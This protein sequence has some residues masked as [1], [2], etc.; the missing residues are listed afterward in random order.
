MV[1][2]GKVKETFAVQSRVSP[3]D[4]YADCT[5]KLAVVSFSDQKF[6]WPSP[7]LPGGQKHGFPQHF[8]TLKI[9]CRRAADAKLQR[10]CHKLDITA[11]GAK[12]KALERS[13][14]LGRLNLAM[15]TMRPCFFMPNKPLIKQ[16]TIYFYTDLCH[17]QTKPTGFEP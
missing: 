2:E 15:T 12:R 9:I 17:S 13:E 8:E 1:G 6:S 10:F 14:L 3:D 5:K 16:M 4:L 11:T 7:Q